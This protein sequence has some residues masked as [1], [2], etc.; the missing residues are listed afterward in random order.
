MQLFI[1]VFLAHSQWQNGR[2]WPASINWDGTGPE[3][4]K[5]LGICKPR[6]TSFSKDE[7]VRHIRQGSGSAVG[8][9]HSVGEG[10]MTARTPLNI[11][12]TQL[13]LAWERPFSKEEIDSKNGSDDHGLYQIYC[14]HLVFGAGT[15]VYISKAEKQTFAQRLNRHWENWAKYESDVS[16]RLARRGVAT[17]Q[18]KQLLSDA[19]MLTV[20]WHTPLYNSE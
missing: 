2:G 15:L 8:N 12:F 11:S 19:E 5:Q 3:Q 1:T 7:L 6:E 16:F 20:Y 10:I 4:R 14:H 13:F 9:A 18:E 17:R